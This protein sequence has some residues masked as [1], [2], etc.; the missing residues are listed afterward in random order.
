M[1]ADQ[2]RGGF[3]V[4][5]RIDGFR[6]QPQAREGRVVAGDRGDQQVGFGV[7]LLR[8]GGEVGDRDPDRDQD[9]D[10]DQQ[11]AL[12][13]RGDVALQSFLLFC[14]LEPVGGWVRRG[15]H[16]YGTFGARDDRPARAAL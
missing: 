4:A 10:Q 8:C 2:L 5:R 6:D 11:P 7:V 14:R 1:L 12:A 3:D 16:R 13:N 15:C 9:R